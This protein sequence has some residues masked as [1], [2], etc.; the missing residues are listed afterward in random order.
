MMMLFLIVFFIVCVLFLEVIN[1]FLERFSV[2]FSPHINLPAIL[3]ENCVE[4]QISEI[5]E[6]DLEEK[7]D[8]RFTL[9]FN[10]IRGYLE[11]LK[12]VSLVLQDNKVLSCSVVIIFFSKYYRCVVF[13]SEDILFLIVIDDSNRELPVFK[14]FKLKG[15]LVEKYILLRDLSGY[16]DKS[17]SYDWCQKAR[18]SSVLTKYKGFSVYKDRCFFWIPFVFRTK[19]KDLENYD[20]Q[21]LKKN[22]YSVFRSKPSFIYTYKRLGFRD[23]RIV[24]TFFD[25]Y[26]KL[27]GNQNI[28]LTCLYYKE[29]PDTTEVYSRLR[30]VHIVGHLNILDI[31]SRVVYERDY[32]TY[33]SSRYTSDRKPFYYF[34]ETLRYHLDFFKLREKIDLE[35]DMEE[36]RAFPIYYRSRSYDKFKYGSVFPTPDYTYAYEKIWTDQYKVEP[37]K[38]SEL[39]C[40]YWFSN[41]SE[42]RN[43]AYFCSIT[44][45][46]GGSSDN[47]LYILEYSYNPASR[48]SSLDCLIDVSE[49]YPK[50]LLKIYNYKGSGGLRRIHSYPIV[51]SKLFVF[52][53]VSCFRE[54]ACTYKDG[55]YLEYYAKVRELVRT[56]PW[57]QTITFWK[58]PRVSGLIA[59]NSKF[60]TAFLRSYKPW[61]KYWK[62]FYDHFLVWG[63]PEETENPGYSPVVSDLCFVGTSPIGPYKDRV[64]MDPGCDKAK[65]LMKLSLKAKLFLSPKLK[66]TESVISKEGRRKLE[67]I[68]ASKNMLNLFV[69]QKVDNRVDTKKTNKEKRKEFDF[70]SSKSFND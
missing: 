18:A 19:P 16:T 9:S 8:A 68:L 64:F 50:Q 33:D 6:I 67:A 53:M 13:F 3:N 36:N 23:E 2:L 63:F 58:L 41:I 26:Y 43:L 17:L 59:L 57:E 47:F 7:E 32:L 49:I 29:D 15:F 1:S 38:R 48:N 14:T 42:L 11:E 69:R 40:S 45:Y 27:L 65:S 20:F 52:S 46:S 30:I 70:F 44:G 37:Y 10:L 12:E 54:S 60:R 4:N 35:D 25:G 61:N 31:R 34:I 22:C 5:K 56:E 62:F 21:I 66:N 55:W 51:M 24:H 39:S 28:G